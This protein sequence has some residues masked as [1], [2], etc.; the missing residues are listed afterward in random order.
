MVIGRVM[1][2]FAQEPGT[3]ASNEYALI[4]NFDAV[5][6]A[7]KRTYPTTRA[8]PGYQLYFS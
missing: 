2:A 3:V 1:V 4:A 7:A 6:L 5:A 8:F